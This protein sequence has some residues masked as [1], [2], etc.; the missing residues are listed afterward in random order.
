VSTKI[1]IITE[2]VIDDLLL[3]ALLE[4]IARD[5]AHFTWPVMPDDLGQIFP[6][7]KRG[8][9][10]VV[11]VLQRLVTF[12]ER[13]PPTDHAFFVILLDRRTRYAQEAVKKLIRGKSLFIVGIAIEEVEA[14]WLADRENTLAW[15]DLPDYSQNDCRYWNKGYRAEEDDKPKLTLDQLTMLSERLDRRYGHGNKQ[16]AEDFAE[17]WKETAKLSVIEH[18]CPMGFKPFCQEVTEFLNREKKSRGRL[19]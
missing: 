10:G 12:L 6:I 14:W 2:G 1:G 19:F 5:R 8:H 9:G 16:L 4:R 15:L 11:D 18:E 17:I 7:R 13:N 3:P